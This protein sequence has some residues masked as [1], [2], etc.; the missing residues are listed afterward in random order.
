[1]LG[2]AGILAIIFL[3]LLLGVASLGIGY[4]LAH[5]PENKDF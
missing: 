5:L 1:M 4:L 3:F 2:L